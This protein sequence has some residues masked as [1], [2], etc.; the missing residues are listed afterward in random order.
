M[1]R[2]RIQEAIW[3]AYK[4][5][6][7]L[8]EGFYNSSDS[9][10]SSSSDENSE[11]SKKEVLLKLC[12]EADNIIMH[13]FPLPKRR[14]GRRARLDLIK[15]TPSKLNAATEH[16]ALLGSKDLSLSKAELFALGATPLLLAVRR[17][18][19][20]RIFAHRVGKHYPP[21]MVE[22]GMKQLN[23]L[24]GN[25]DHSTLVELLTM[26]WLEG[27]K[28]IKVVPEGTTAERD[29][30]F[31]QRV[32]SIREANPSLSENKAMELAAEGTDLEDMDDAAR[33]KA[34]RRGQARAARRK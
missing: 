31:A 27:G 26:D 29:L 10:Q 18:N 6:E 32:A 5:T 14:P 24:V 8:A 7:N 33:R 4:T 21:E 1:K 25:P 17:Q 11:Q 15:M 13:L 9:S 28:G 20:F 19:A 3:A 16:L 12:S 34:L 23:S 30:T 22:V 2:T